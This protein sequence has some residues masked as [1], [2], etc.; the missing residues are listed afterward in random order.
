MPEVCFKFG[1]F[2]PMITYFSLIC[3]LWDDEELT[4]AGF[5]KSAQRLREVVREH[6]KVAWNIAVRNNLDF[7]PNCPIKP[8]PIP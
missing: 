1:T 6:E 5:V 2:C 7:H 8:V 4:E 3:N